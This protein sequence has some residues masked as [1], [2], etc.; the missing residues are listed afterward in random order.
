[1][2]TTVSDAVTY[3]DAIPKH[4]VSIKTNKVNTEISSR[5]TEKVLFPR[6]SLPRYPMTVINIRIKQRRFPDSI[7]TVSG[8]DAIMEITPA[9][10]IDIMKRKVKLKTI[11]LRNAAGETTTVSVPATIPNI[12]E[13]P[14]YFFGTVAPLTSRAFFSV[15]IPNASRNIGPIIRALDTE[16]ISERFEKESGIAAPPIARTVRNSSNAASPPAEYIIINAKIENSAYVN[17][18]RPIERN[19]ILRKSEKPLRHTR[20][21]MLFSTPEVMNRST[22]FIRLLRLDCPSIKLPEK[23][24]PNLRVE[25]D[26]EAIRRQRTLSEKASDVYFINERIAE[27]I[28]LPCTAVLSLSRFNQITSMHL[29]TFFREG[30]DVFLPSPEPPPHISTYLYFR[31]VPK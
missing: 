20:E 19:R 13:S 2:N 10:G 9:S 8:I 26:L 14:E 30:R 17:K 5:S 15:S 18:K 12:S 16:D 11:K 23:L 25:F 24:L 27:S 1:M 4:D 22:F 6:I 7:E 28:R 3:D 29:L 31:D 21:S